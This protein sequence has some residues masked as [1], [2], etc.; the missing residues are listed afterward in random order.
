MKFGC[1]LIYVED[2]IK[3]IEFY[4]NAFGFERSFVYEDNGV[5]LYAE[6]KTG[7]TAIGFSSFILG[8]MNFKGNYQKISNNGSPV[9][10]ELV[11]FDNNVESATNKAVDFGARLIESPHK[12]PWGQTVSFIRSIEGTLI[13]ICSPMQ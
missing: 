2:V 3:T 8:E 5:A 6:L 4:Q 12:K 7:E 11:F 10:L 1:T 13:E 9:G